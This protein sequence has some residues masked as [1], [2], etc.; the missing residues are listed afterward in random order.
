MTFKANLDDADS[1]AFW[2]AV[3]RGARAYN[4]LPSWQKGVL[5]GLERDDDQSGQEVGGE[6]AELPDN[7]SAAG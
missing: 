6:K 5:G 3:E 7:E 4:D 2:D 1:R